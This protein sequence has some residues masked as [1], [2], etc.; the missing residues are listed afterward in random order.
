MAMLKGM[1]FVAIT[2]RVPPASGTL[3]TLP[4]DAR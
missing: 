3:A 2:E 4:G 1:T